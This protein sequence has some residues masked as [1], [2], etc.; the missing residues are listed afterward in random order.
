M[1]PGHHSLH[2]YAPGGAGLGLSYQE[3]LCVCTWL[4]FQVNHLQSL[5]LRGAVKAPRRQKTQAKLKL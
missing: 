3:K 1:W 5:P 4:K 2:S